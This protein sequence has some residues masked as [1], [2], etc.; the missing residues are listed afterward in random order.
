[1]TSSSVDR[2]RSDNLLVIHDISLH[3]MGFGNQECQQTNHIHKCFCRWMENCPD[4]L[5]KNLG[6]IEFLWGLPNIWLNLINVRVTLERIFLLSICH[7]FPCSSSYYGLGFI[8]KRIM[9]DQQKR[10]L[11][12]SGHNT[13][14]A[15]RYRMLRNRTLL[16]QRQ[17]DSLR[18][19][20]CYHKHYLRIGVNQR[21]CLLLFSKPG[22]LQLEA[23][24]SGVAKFCVGIKDP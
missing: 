4:A 21:Q 11:M 19:C 3:R 7:T 10:V 9:F 12:Q 15:A 23:A 24:S 16:V 1:M 18:K 22:R 6:T 8:E 17:F 14:F 20:W 2:R 5:H 13:Y